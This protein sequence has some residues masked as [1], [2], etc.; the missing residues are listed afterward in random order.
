MNFCFYPLRI[1]SDCRSHQCHQYFYDVDKWSG[2]R[3]EYVTSPP[4]LRL[5][6]WRRCGGSASSQS[7]FMK[8]IDYGV[9]LSCSGKGYSF[10]FPTGSLSDVSV[11]HSSPTQAPISPLHLVI[12]L[13]LLLQ[14]LACHY[15]TL[16]VRLSSVS[17]TIWLITFH[18]DHT[19]TIPWHTHTHN[20]YHFES[21]QVSGNLGQNMIKYDTTNL[22]QSRKGTNRLSH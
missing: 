9:I 14:S 7:A 18:P 8:W 12:C 5:A 22:T 6:Q 16:F 1:K 3:S 20:L 17:C 19:H 11:L 2:S 21:T 10:T 15:V 13:P 4:P